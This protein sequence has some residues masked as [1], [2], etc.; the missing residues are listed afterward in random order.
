MLKTAQHNQSKSSTIQFPLAHLMISFFIC[1]QKYLSLIVAKKIQYTTEAFETTFYHS[2][3]IHLVLDFIYANHKEISSIDFILTKIL[4]AVS[5][6]GEINRVERF[7]HENG[8]NSSRLLGDL[9]AAKAE[10][11]WADKY[12]PVIMEAMQQNS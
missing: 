8:L 12:V 5:T 4:R 10:L 3:H 2:Q 6:S 9:E 7:M 1:F 11:R